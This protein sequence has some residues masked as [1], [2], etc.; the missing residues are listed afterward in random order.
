[1]IKQ[2]LCA[3]VRSIDV[4]PLGCFDFFND[5]ESDLHLKVMG[6]GW[7]RSLVKA[8]RRETRNI[9]RKMN[10]EVAAREPFPCSVI[11]PWSLHHVGTL[12]AFAHF[13]LSRG[14]CHS[15]PQW[16]HCV[17]EG[18]CLCGVITCLSEF[19]SFPSLFQHG[20]W[21]QGGAHGSP[22]SLLA[23]SGWP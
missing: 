11:P 14:F 20:V 22:S 23:G 9:W 5:K 16:T 2:G 13:L 18:S 4:P 7:G 8:V 12:Y 19:T 21:V 1:M 3:G 17:C 15:I 10:K 6:K